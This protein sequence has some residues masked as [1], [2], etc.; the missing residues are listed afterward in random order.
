MGEMTEKTKRLEE[1]LRQKEEE[2]ERLRS[3]MKDA[4]KKTEEGADTKEHELNALR[5]QIEALTA[6]TNEEKSVWQ[7]VKSENEKLT[8]T[9]A[10]LNESLE[11]AREELASKR[12]EVQNVEDM[13]ENTDPEVASLKVE[14]KALK[15]QLTETQFVKES[16]GEANAQL[17]EQVEEAKNNGGTLS[18]QWSATQAGDAASSNDE[19]VTS[20]EAEVKRLLAINRSL[21]EK[22]QDTQSE[23][24]TLLFESDSDLQKTNAHLEAQ[25]AEILTKNTTLESQAAQLL[26]ESADLK[27]G[28]VV[29]ESANLTATTNELTSELLVLFPGI[30]MSNLYRSDLINLKAYIHYVDRGV[31][32]RLSSP[33][34]MEADQQGAMDEVQ[35]M[36]DAGWTEAD[37]AAEFARL[38][39]EMIKSGDWSQFV[40]EDHGVRRVTLA[41]LLTHLA[42]THQSPPLLDAPSPSDPPLGS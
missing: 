30:D 23:S 14:L 22:R 33:E 19:K 38:A 18:P 1:S 28:A 41:T 37:F 25:L 36:T 17:R 6:M 24:P 39:G 7:S 34:E 2:L 15:A 9:V 42:S 4:I 32:H 13:A 3:E 29:A 5:Q 40:G 12:T 10:A 27:S 31:F 21:N 8:S 11:A 20:L 26:K 16:L 35:A